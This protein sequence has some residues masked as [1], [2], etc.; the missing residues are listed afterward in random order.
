MAPSK[1]PP[2]DAGLGPL[3]RQVM[4]VLWEATTTMTVREVLQSIN[5]GRRQPLAYT[6]V[7]TTLAR[8]TN[9]GVVR[10]AREGRGYRYAA[11]V[12]D[13]AAVAVRG[14]VRDFGDAALA[15]FVDEIDAD[16]ELRRRL[17]L[18]LGEDG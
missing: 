6:T 13:T 18:M 9:K 10:R 3:E 11:A 8:L 7:M 17:R 4:A 16:P 5:A 2:G 14:V 15:H 1:Q 12:S